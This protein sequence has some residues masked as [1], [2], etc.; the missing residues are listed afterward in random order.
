[1]EADLSGFMTLAFTIG[2]NG[3][4]TA[5]RV[6]DSTL[7][8]PAL[9]RCIEAAV[10]ELT[11]VAPEGVSSVNVRYPLM[12]WPPPMTIRIPAGTELFNASGARVGRMLEETSV[13]LDEEH[14][15]ATRNCFAVPLAGPVHAAS[16]LFVCVPTGRR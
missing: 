3:R 16:P 1:M 8:Q 7:E 12:L 5:A 9:T 4:V 11:F 2:A 14:S 13:G 6:E 15:S 10:R